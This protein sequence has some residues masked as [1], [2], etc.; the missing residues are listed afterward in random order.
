MAYIVEEKHIKTIQMY[1]TLKRSPWL[2]LVLI[3]YPVLTALC[4]AS[5]M[6]LYST[7]V[8]DGFNAVT[9]LV[10]ARDVDL[11]IL[12]GAT[13]TSEL[14][15]RITVAFVIE[16]LGVGEE[17]VRRVKLEMNAASRLKSVVRSGQIYG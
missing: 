15:K 4:L 9:L 17:R 14:A 13:L 2:A 6:S 7:P 10:A 12:D 3:M 8:G 5:Q 11:I 16:D 1:A